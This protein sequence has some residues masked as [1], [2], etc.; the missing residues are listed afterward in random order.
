MILPYAILFTYD[1][2]AKGSLALVALLNIGLLL[3]LPQTYDMMDE[4]SVAVFIMVYTLALL[5]VLWSCKS[6]WVLHRN[7]GENTSAND[8]AT[9]ETNDVSNI[10]D[11]GDQSAS[12]HE[13]N[14]TLASA[15]KLAYSAFDD[16]DRDGLMV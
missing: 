8:E 1:Y 5:S 13:L 6:R 16:G 2:R 10:E 14:S 4:S 9:Y 15:E 12:D 7:A 11:I 3:C